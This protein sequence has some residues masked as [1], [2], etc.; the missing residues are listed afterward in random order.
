MEGAT[1]LL[2]SSPLKILPHR[3]RRWL[4]LCRYQR[5]RKVAQSVVRLN[6]NN[7]LCLQLL[8]LRRQPR[9]TLSLS[10]VARA[11]EFAR[12]QSRLNCVIVNMGIPHHR[13]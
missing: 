12:F 8:L 3:L 1:L 6:H 9:L 13:R 10:Y 4:F 5:R 2:F 11:L 7:S